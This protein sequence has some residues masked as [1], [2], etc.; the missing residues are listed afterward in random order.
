M[1]LLHAYYAYIL[2]FCLA[3]VD[4]GTLPQMHNGYTI[5]VTN[6]T[7]FQSVAHYFC[8]NGY[9]LD[10]HMNRTCESTAKW[11]GDEPVCKGRTVLHL[12]S[13]I[14]ALDLLVVLFHSAVDCEHPG[15]PDN[16]QVEVS[17]T[18]FESEVSYAC[19]DGYY[20]DGISTRFCQ[21]NGTWSGY[22]PSCRST[23]NT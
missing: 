19:S 9:Y 22:L 14:D 11:S 6:T 18:T 20:I 12:L 8:D 23:Y 17:T 1:T 10:G 4:C 16:G 13:D 15:T 21:A 3:A 7:V 2:W 5:T